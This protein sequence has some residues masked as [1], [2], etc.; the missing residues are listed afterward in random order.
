MYINYCSYRL[1]KDGES[2]VDTM[3][4]PADHEAAIM[5]GVNVVPPPPRQKKRTSSFGKSSSSS[6][7]LRSASKEQAVAGSSKEQPETSQGIM[8]ICN[9]HYTYIV[10]TIATPNYG[11]SP[12]HKAI[13]AC[14]AT[15]PGDQPR[16]VNVYYC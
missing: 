11:P 7:L 1:C 2:S 6:R 3:Q 8:A 14:I 12:L 13:Q 5:S 16:P 4:L 9:V 10:H 15:A